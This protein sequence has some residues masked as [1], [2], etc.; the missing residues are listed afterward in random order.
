MKKV[1]CLL[2]AVLSVIWLAACSRDSN[3]ITVYEQLAAEDEIMPTLD[4]LGDYVS[5]FLGADGILLPNIQR[6]TML[7]KKRGSRKAIFLKIIRTTRGRAKGMRPAKAV[8]MR[9]G[10]DHMF[11]EDLMIS[12]ISAVRHM[13]ISRSWCI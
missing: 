13:K 8:P 3:D 12:P 11:L 9:C 6:K 1:F 4:E 10:R 2:F 7:Y 5:F